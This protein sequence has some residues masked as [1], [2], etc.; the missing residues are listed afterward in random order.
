[1]MAILGRWVDFTGQAITWDQAINSNHS[2]VPSKYALDG[3][4]PVVPG[5]DGQYPIAM[6]GVTPFPG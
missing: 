2:F 6:P 5:A 1:M 3:T 4:P